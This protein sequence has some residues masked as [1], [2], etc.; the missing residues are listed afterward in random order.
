MEQG[1]DNKNLYENETFNKKKNN[2]MKEYGILSL[3]LLIICGMVSICWLNFDSI[4]EFFDEVIEDYDEY[5]NYDEYDG[6]DECYDC[7][8]DQT[9]I[10]EYD[11]EIAKAFFTDYLGTIEDYRIG[12]AQYVDG[13]FVMEYVTY[14]YEDGTYDCVYAETY[15]FK[16]YKVTTLEAPNMNLE[17]AIYKIYNLKDE[18]L[19]SRINSLAL[20]YNYLEKDETMINN[21]LSYILSIDSGEL[22]TLYN[23]KK[24]VVTTKKYDNYSIEYKFVDSSNS[25]NT[26]ILSCSG[27]CVKK[28]EVY[29]TSNVNDFGESDNVFFDGTYYYLE[30]EI[31]LDDSQYLK[32]KDFVGNKYE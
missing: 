7:Y 31:V 2:N 22:T 11:M 6:I 28:W 12:N 1:N 10:E 30:Y 27:D 16:D 9:D 8:I 21:L 15:D 17:E 4:V 25:D 13:W 20:Q 5:D 3:F 32:A 18:E 24:Y 26:I 14:V 23:S 29:G 19:A